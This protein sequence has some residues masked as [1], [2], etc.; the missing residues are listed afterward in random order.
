VAV[1]ETLLTSRHRGKFSAIVSHTVSLKTGV[2]TPGP[3]VQ[4]FSI[5][6]IRIKRR[7]ISIP[8]KD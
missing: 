7:D 5:A 1:A 4:S 3:V 8:N 2:L 6:E